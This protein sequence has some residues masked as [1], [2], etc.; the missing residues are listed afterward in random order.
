MVNIAKSH[1]YIHLDHDPEYLEYLAYLHEIK[2][3]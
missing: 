2:F 1:M 3:N